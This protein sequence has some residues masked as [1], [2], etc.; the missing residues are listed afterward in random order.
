MEWF[1]NRVAAETLVPSEDFLAR[2][3]S[4]DTS[5]RDNLDSLRRYYKV[6][7]MVV[8][9]Q[10]LDNDLIDTPEYQKRCAQLIGNAEAAEADR[11]SADEGDD[12]SFGNFYH[13]LIARNGRMFT[14]A[15]IAGAA[16][17]TTLSS[18][19]AYMLDVK[20]RTLSEIA[21]HVSRG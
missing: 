5:L 3:R 17:G 2:W 19:A 16:Q 9:R 14:E 21:K 18:E 8:L 15:V 11:K 7:S 4:G 6:S 12:K 10:A 1:C 20:I 13:T